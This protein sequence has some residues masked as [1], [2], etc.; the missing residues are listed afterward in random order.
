MVDGDP[1]LEELIRTNESSVI[2]D[3]RRLSRFPRFEKAFES[4]LQNHGHREIEFDIYHPTWIEVPWVVLDNIRLMLDADSKTNP[5]E[6]QVEL[7]ITMQQTEYACLQQL[8]DNLHFFFHEL[9]RLARVYTSV[10]DLEHYEPT[11]LTLPMR[12]G[13]REPG[14]RLCERGV[15]DEPMD[16]YFSHVRPLADAIRRDRQVDW[17]AVADGIHAE[18]RAYVADRGRTPHWVLGEDRDTGQRGGYLQGLPGSP[19]RMDGQA[20]LVRGPDDFA[21]FPKGAVLVARTTN[22]TWTPLFY[23]A[24]AVITESGGPLSHGAVIAREMK[25]P[26]VTSVRNV[27]SIVH[28]GQ[29]VSVDGAAGRV[30]LG[31]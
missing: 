8:P 2:L 9:G 5:S 7:K 3:D 29:S 13:L 23:S 26:A 16:V 12:R 15:I 22:P 24:A 30:Y 21:R 20:F 25:I 19:G 6:K 31:E 18:K 17:D 27:L 1:A 11:R 14:R 10:D 28:S 4:F